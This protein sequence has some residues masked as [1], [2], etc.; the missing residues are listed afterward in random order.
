ML[1]YMKFSPITFFLEKI[2]MVYHGISYISL[3]QDDLKIKVKKNWTY[4]IHILGKSFVIK[5]KVY[6]F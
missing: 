5:S 2:N 3:P 6:F 4:Q 1:F